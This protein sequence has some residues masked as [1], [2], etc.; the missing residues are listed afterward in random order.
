LAS[1]I[2]ATKPYNFVL[3]INIQNCLKEIEDIF[4]LFK[5]EKYSIVK[6]RYIFILKKKGEKTDLLRLFRELIGKI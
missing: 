4:S 6:L 2:K 3:P 5:K 1:E